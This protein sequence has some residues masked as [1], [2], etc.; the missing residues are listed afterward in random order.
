[1]PV[2][3]SCSLAPFLNVTV[4]VS[5]TCRPRSFAGSLLTKMPLARSASSP[6][7]MPRS[8]SCGN[9]AAS[10]TLKSFWSAAESAVATSAWMK[11]TP[12]TADSSG[13]WLSWVAMS[14]VR[15]PNPFGC[16]T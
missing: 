9:A 14:V 6:S 5:P 10:T 3:G 15:V 11:R 13:S 7:I 4:T 16:T 8:T 2:T 1:M 12:L